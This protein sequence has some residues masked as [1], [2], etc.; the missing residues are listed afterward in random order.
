MS[1]TKTRAQEIESISLDVLADC[2]GPERDRLVPP[3]NLKKILDKYGIQ[4]N[5]GGFKDQ[6]ILGAYEK[7]SKTIYIDGN[8]IYPRKAFTIAHELGHYFLHEDKKADFF[9]RSEALKLEQNA[10][11]EVEANKFAASLLMPRF[12]VER[13]WLQFKSERVIAHIF[14]VSNAAANFRLKNLNLSK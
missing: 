13:F 6:N 5:V 1:I 10:V 3:I 12:L 11:E 2:F 8:E 7:H 14:K 9:Y 4:L